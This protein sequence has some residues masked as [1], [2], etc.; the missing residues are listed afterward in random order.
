[1]T[2][3]PPNLIPMSYNETVNYPNKLL[4]I[5][6]RDQLKQ[7][8]IEDSERL[9]NKIN[10]AIDKILRDETGSFMEFPETIENKI[11]PSIRNQVVSHLTGIEVRVLT[12]IL[13]L[14]QIAESDN[15]IV[16]NKKNNSVTFSFDRLR[17]NAL[18]GLD[19]KTA[20][21]KHRKI[22]FDAL[23][24]LDKKKFIVPCRNGDIRFPRLVN[25]DKTNVNNKKITVTVDESF[26]VLQDKES[27]YFEL[28]SN[29]NKKLREI[30]TGR[31]NVGVEL[32]IKCLYQAKHCS[33]DNTVEYSYGRL[34]EIMRLENHLKKRNHSRIRKTIDK[35]FLTAKKFNLIA[36]FKEGRTRFSEVK[37]IITF[38]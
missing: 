25:I 33:K 26:I 20:S 32:F 7:L 36:S 21:S 23:I 13:V 34:I 12:A 27:T 15:D 5:E 35:A 37:Y 2:V 11:D 28:P 8:S 16:H 22:I 9:N 1:M 18:M 3:L 31:P 30:S 24:E 14:C 6:V 17:F 19:S 38:K 10:D 4:K 29:I